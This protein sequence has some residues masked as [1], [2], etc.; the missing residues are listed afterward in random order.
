MARNLKRAAFSAA[1]WSALD[2]FGVQIVQ[3]VIGVVLARLLAPADFGLIAMLAVFIALAEVFVDSGL[4]SALIQKREVTAQDE[5]TM[6]YVNIAMAVVAYGLLWLAA[7]YIAQFYQQ[8][9]LK[10]LLRVLALV[11]IIRSLAI[12]QTTFLRKRLDFRSLFFRSL[13]SFPVSGAVGIIMAYRG[14]GVWSL[15]TQQLVGASLNVI[16]YWVKSH[17]WPR[18]IFSLESFKKLTGFGSRQLAA[19]L[20]D[21]L[22]QNIYHIVIG[23]L[24]SAAPLGYYARAVSLQRLAT[25]NLSTIVS[26]VAFPVFCTVHHDVDRLREVASR[27]LAML[28]MVMFPIM[29]GLMVVATPLVDVLLSAKWL[30]C[31]PY[32]RLLCIIGILYPL[33]VVNVN[34]LRA[35][36]EMSVYLR[37]E[38][39]KKA[40]TIVAILLTYRWGILAMV[41]GQVIQSLVNYHLNAHFGGKSIGYSWQAQF[42]DILPYMGAALVMAAAAVTVGFMV[43]EPP[44]AKLLL[45]ASAGA[46]TYVACCRL[47]R[48][49]EFKDAWEWVVHCVGTLSGRIRPVGV[50]G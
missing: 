12:I 1:T 26:R 28:A 29:V 17:W 43:P 3:F 27:T 42:R 48:L 14:F 32:F 24:F 34:V 46:I 5:N 31:V 2:T 50:R 37:L 30:P 23:R 22:F 21:T 33:H 9:A 4:S 39:V 8:P 16:C 25:N 19:G 15:V 45:Q 10:A 20:L 38:F 49:P 40:V 13:L 36:G 41:W 11:I 47:L 35:R 18:L 6:F 44:L 7:P